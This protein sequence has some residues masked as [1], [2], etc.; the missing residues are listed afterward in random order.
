MWPEMQ[1]DCHAH[2]CH[3]ARH[4]CTCPSATWLAWHHV[5]ACGAATPPKTLTCSAAST[6]ASMARTF[7]SILLK[8]ASPVLVLARTPAS[9]RAR[10]QIVSL[11]QSHQ[12]GHTPKNQSRHNFRPGAAKG[13]RAAYLMQHP[14]GA[15]RLARGLP[16]RKA[17]QKW[18]SATAEVS[19]YATAEATALGSLPNKQPHAGGGAQWTCTGDS[20]HTCSD[21]GTLQSACSA[22]VHSACCVH[23]YL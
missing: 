5:Q 15:L 18:R 2:C 8:A 16:S 19:G 22:A 7:S 11:V 6:S 1:H 14:K 4:P 17:C 21:T 9:C 23:M 10:H 13:S 3:L 12:K 20:A